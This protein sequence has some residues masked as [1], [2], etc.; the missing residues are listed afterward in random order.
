MGRLARRRWFYPRA[1]ARLLDGSGANQKIIEGNARRR[2]WTDENPASGWGADC[3]RLA[4]GSGLC[5]P[6][7]HYRVPDGRPWALL[8]HGDETPRI[9]VG[10]LHHRGSPTGVDLVKEAES[11]SRPGRPLSHWMHNAKRKYH[12]IRVPDQRGKDPFNNFPALRGQRSNFTTAPGRSRAF[13]I[14]SP[15]L[16]RATPCAAHY[17]SMI[18]KVIGM[19]DGPRETRHRSAMR[20]G[21]RRVPHPRPSRPRSPFSRPIMHDPDFRAGANTTPASS[22]SWIEAAGGRSFGKV[23]SNQCFSNQLIPC[24]PPPSDY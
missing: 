20:P 21:T 7:G 19:G 18:A 1:G 14:D 8:L 11:R 5:R 13:R 17:D 24:P 22:P 16:R 10:A 23:I 6:R 9:Q 15:R 2:S 4:Q 12:A 3:V